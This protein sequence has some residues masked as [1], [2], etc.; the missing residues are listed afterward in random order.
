MKKMLQ[1]LVYWG[2]T[3]ALG[4]GVLAILGIMVLGST[5]LFSEANGGSNRAVASVLDV[6]DIDAAR[7]LVR[8]SIAETFVTGAAGADCTAP[9]PAGIGCPAGTY[10][11]KV[12]GPSGSSGS[13]R[14]GNAPAGIKAE[15]NVASPCVNSKVVPSADLTKKIF[16]FVNKG[17][18]TNGGRAARATC[19]VTP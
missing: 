5:A 11:V 3:F 16:C 6:A 15:C 18:A 7:A 9:D 2:K 19:T 14:C 8:C 4:L 17:G 12:S 13:I 10:T 1:I